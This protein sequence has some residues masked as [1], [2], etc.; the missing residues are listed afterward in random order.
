[1]L[2]NN[3]ETINNEN[4]GGKRKANE[5]YWC[6]VLN[7]EAAKATKQIVLDMLSQ[8]NW[9]YHKKGYT[10]WIQQNDRW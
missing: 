10:F 2:G 1:M 8:K 9:I 3:N 4:H 5:Q 7:D 6:P